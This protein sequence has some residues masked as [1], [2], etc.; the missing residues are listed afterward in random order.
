MTVSAIREISH[1]NEELGEDKCDFG[2]NKGILVKTKTIDKDAAQP[3]KSL[4][5]F[6]SLKNKSLDHETFGVGMGD[7]VLM[8]T[9]KTDGKQSEGSIR[10]E[11]ESMGV[12]DS[13]KKKSFDQVESGR[14]REEVSG[15]ERLDSKT[16]CGRKNKGNVPKRKYRKKNASCQRT[17]HLGVSDEQNSLEHNEYDGHD[18]GGA[19]SAREKVKEALFLFRKLLQEDADTKE[20]RP[21]HKRVDYQVAKILEDDKKTV[22]TDIKL[23]GHLPGVEVGDEFKCR[24]E[25]SIIGLH[26]QTQSGISCSKH[27]GKTIAASIVASEDHTDDLDN[28][29][30]LIYTGQGSSVYSVKKPEDQKLE[31]GNLALKNSMDEK[32]PI[33]V[34]RGCDPYKRRFRKFVYIGLYLVESYRQVKGPQG[35]LVYK[36]WLERIP[37]QPEV[38]YKEVKKSKRPKAQKGVCL[39]DVSQEKVIQTCAV[40]TTDENPPPFQYRTTERIPDQPEVAQKE[41]K[42]TN[43]SNAHKG[44]SLDDISPGKGVSPTRHVVNTIDDDPPPLKYRAIEL[45]EAQK[46]VKK[47]EKSEPQKGVRLDDISHGKVVIP[48]CAVN[49]NDDEIPPPLR[50]KTIKT[51]PD[52]P[53]VGQKGV[54]KRKRS[55][56]LKGV[57]LD[58][59]SHGKEVIPIRDVNTNDDERPPPLKYKTIK[60]IPGEPEVAQKGVKKRKR[61]KSQK[62]ICLDDISHGKEV[63]P[64]CA[65]N[66]IDDEKPPSF[67]Y[68]TNLVYPD[69]CHIT[70]PKGCDCIDGCSDSKICSCAVKNG[71]KMPYNSNGTAVNEK[72]LVYECG[73]SC[74]CP[75]SCRNR[76][77]QH[78]I[79]FK[80]EIFKTKL[81]GWG[82]RSQEC[83]PIGSFICEY[84][85][86]LLKDEEAEKRAGYDDYL[87][88]IGKNYDCNTN[89]DE[90]L[91]SCEDVDDD[92]GFTI[93]AAEYGNV[94]RFINH[95]CTPNIYAQKILYNHEDDSI[96]HI[97][98]F[99]A[100]KIHPFQ[101]L[102]YDYHYII[103]QVRDANGNIKKK[104][105]FCGSRECTGRL[106]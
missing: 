6:V 47:S 101:E 45:D 92:D 70:P 61:S 39:G 81:R 82:L 17:S 76:V 77:S 102:T 103:D 21:R 15:V 55:K 94:G 59:I 8:E 60:S 11:Q 95:S 18:G 30:V 10:R 97:M 46:E 42:L 80:L 100:E 91:N 40:D 86:E 66:N 71:G 49:T 27:G 58:D 33:R 14:G 35:N 9:V 34:I 29:N 98:F 56:S 32:T 74:K 25:L 68:T 31:G 105:C 2:V 69:W 85:G 50:Y 37:G 22:N 41:V 5:S 62:S 13:L 79:K 89:I 28:S 65:V 16:S 38:V 1:V 73:P 51:I 53:E 57:C 104:S 12:L 52:E 23:L 87:F 20:E 4:K 75:P 90:D 43:K 106:Y 36:F 67:K 24:M 26:R 93:D 19:S 72:L 88:D 96:P 99:A 64:I 84:I 44:V 83:I 54:K 48:T 3:K 78:G 63:I 7:E